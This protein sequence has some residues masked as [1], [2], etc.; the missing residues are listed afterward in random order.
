M[1]KLFETVLNIY[2]IEEL[3]GRIVTTLTLLLVYRL[4]AQ[5]VLPGIDSVQLAELANRTDGGGLLGILNAFTGGAFA[6]ASV[7]ALGIMPYISA[8]IV[9]Q[10][11]GIAVPYLQ[12]LQKEGESGNK[13]RTQ[14]TRWLTILIC[15][16]Q[17]PAYLYGLSALGVPDSAFVIGRGPLFMISS[18]IILVTGTIFAMWL[19]E[20]ITDKGIGNGISLLI[21]V[22]IIANLPL[23]FTQEFVSRVSENNGG[24]MMILIELV[25]WVLIILLSVLLVMAVRQIPVQY[26]RRSAVG[27]NEKNVFGSRQYIPLK[28][29]ASGVMPIIF[30]Q[31]LMFAPAYLGGAFGDSTVGQWLQANFSDIFGLWYNVL[32][33]V[34]IIIFTYFYTAITVPTNKMSDD[35]K[36]SGGF[37]PGIRPGNE[38]SEFLDTVMSHITFP[39]SLYLAVIAV[40]PAVV[41]KLIGIQQGWALFYGGTSLLIMVGVAID[42]IQQ[43]NSYLL[44]RHYDGL[45]SKTSR[46]RRAGT[47]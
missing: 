41:V 11:M 38:T 12:K 17:A 31:A 39:G 5:V 21:M 14:I 34:L 37:V 16:V 35:L 29:N 4:G 32:F 3:R 25:L 22:G 27:T 44:N 40:F 18:V 7:F 10:L 33:A 13:K 19:G 30:A 23:S 24:L 26:A 28:L 9:V 20:K 42:T 15:V 47:I 36:R 8:S 2:N 43:V 46:N 45:M 1:K 6:N